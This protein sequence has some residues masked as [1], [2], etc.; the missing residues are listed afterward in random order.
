M[1]PKS[2]K[3]LDDI[4]DACAFVMEITAGF[5]A[6]DYMAERRTRQ[7]TE[8]NIA[9]IGEALIRLERTDPDTAARMTD[10]RAVIGLRNRIVHEYERIDNVQ[11][12]TII[13]NFLP[14]LHLEV[15]AL[16][17]EAERDLSA[18]ENQENEH[19]P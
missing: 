17:A 3:W 5:S 8:R 2:P 11:V 16:L 7:A 6:A 14:I 19:A 12:W 13:R 1:Q 9:I 10:Y 18:R 15:T 4:A